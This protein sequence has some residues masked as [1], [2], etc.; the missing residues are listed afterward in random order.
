MS[1]VLYKDESYRIIGACFEVYKDKGCGYH[2][3]V[4]QEC[5]G[6]EFDLQDLPAIAKPRLELEYKGHRLEQKFEPDFV[7]FGKIIVELKAL[8]HLID[9]HSAQL[10]NYLKATGF[11]LGLLVN[12][13]H[14]PRLEYL[15]I[16]ADDRWSTRDN[17]PPDLQS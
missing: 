4:Y 17:N 16:V 13:G 8:S 15:R 7:C 2:E 5:L 12:F 9:E 10:M 11:K 3:P 14:H 1:D 6:F